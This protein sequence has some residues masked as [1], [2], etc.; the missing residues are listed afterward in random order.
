MYNIVYQYGISYI[1][2]RS[3]QFYVLVI[4]IWDVMFWSMKIEV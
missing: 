1:E 2:D 3:I 4:N